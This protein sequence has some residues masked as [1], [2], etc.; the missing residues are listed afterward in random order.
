M[1]RDYSGTDTRLPPGMDAYYSVRGA[2]DRYNLG[3]LGMLSDLS[4][5]MAQQQTLGMEMQRQQA[6][7][8]DA[9]ALQQIVDSDAPPELKQR[10]TFAFLSRH[11]PELAAQLQ[12]RM[13]ARDHPMAVGSSAIYKPGTGEFLKNPFSPE[14]VQKPPQTRTIHQGDTE[15]TQEWT[16]TAW[17]DV[18]TAPRYKPAG[19]NVN[20][21]TQEKKEAETVGKGFGEQFNEIMKG[22]FE[23]GG[24]IARLDRMAQL[25]D[26]VKTGMFMPSG[27]QIAAAAQSVGLN[28]DP[29]LG[30]TQAL[31]AL[32]N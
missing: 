12:D 24:K 9:R 3:N 22:G 31:E 11:K 25:M 23:A 7:V 29:K 21:P 10:A 18:S 19:V 8:E 6:M 28:V 16:G 5:R 15:V 2:N 17:K 4:G 13:A 14:N 20:I 27:A 32:S 30:Q 1:A 26:G